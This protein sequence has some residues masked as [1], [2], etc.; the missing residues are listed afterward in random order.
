MIKSRRALGALFSCLLLAACEGALGPTGQQS[1]DLGPGQLDAGAVGDQGSVSP[2]NWSPPNWAGVVGGRVIVPRGPG[3]APMVIE[4]MDGKEKGAIDVAWK[5]PDG[6][7]VT[8]AARD[9]RA[10]DGQ[11]LRAQLEAAI[12]SEYGK[13]LQ[14]LAPELR[15]GLESVIA[16]ACAAAGVPC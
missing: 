15:T 5:Q 4:V 1:L 3:G 10:F 14:E 2:L 8:I 13:T 11:A 7:E 16:A 6:T 12:A 9:V